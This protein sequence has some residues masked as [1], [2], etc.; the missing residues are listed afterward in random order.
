MRH[1]HVNVCAREGQRVVGG[2]IGFEGTLTHMH[3]KIPDEKYMRYICDRAALGYD[4]SS[5]ELT[6]AVARPPSSR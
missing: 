6:M 3:S 4:G 5:M 1:T 2:F